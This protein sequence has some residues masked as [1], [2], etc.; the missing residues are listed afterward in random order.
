MILLASS[1][2]D[3]QLEAMEIRMNPKSEV[4]VFSHK[5]VDWPHWVREK[6]LL[7]VDGFTYL[8]VL[9]TIDGKMEQEIG[10]WIRVDTLVRWVIFQPS[11]VS[12]LGLKV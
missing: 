5:A 10:R 12:R 8:W 2:R 9:F 7:Q 4:T 1:K 6:S 11:A 3:L